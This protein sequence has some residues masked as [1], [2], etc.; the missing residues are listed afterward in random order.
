MFNFNSNF[1]IYS[2]RPQVAH[3]I[4]RHEV[5]ASQSEGVPPKVL[6]KM[7]IQKAGGKVELGKT[8]SLLTQYKNTLSLNSV[9]KEV[10]LGILLGDANLQTQ[11][12]GKTYRLRYEGGDK[13]KSYIQSIHQVF[14]E[15]CLA[16]LA[17]KT[18]IHPNTKSLIKNWEF[19]TLSHEEMNFFASLF[20]NQEGKKR[21][22]E[23]ILEHP[24]FTPRS[25]AYWIMDDGSKMDHTTNQGKG[26]EIHTESF[27]EPEVAY[28]CETLA[29]KYNLKSW[30]KTKKRDGKVYHIVAISGKSYETLLNLIEPYMHNDM[31]HK[32]PT[33]RKIG[34]KP[35]S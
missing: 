22:P 35:V 19:Q 1:P 9:Q 10:G 13:H 25:L 21:V 4:E 28:L 2:T 17:E 5:N 7:L 6:R 33:P 32:L 24:N 26:L 29:K 18:R 3:V 15:W 31:Y 23:N 11:N 20:L 12:K 16:D 30:P 34:R 8:R 14:T 27:L